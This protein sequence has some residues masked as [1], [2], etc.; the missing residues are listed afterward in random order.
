MQS[1]KPLPL[2]KCNAC[3]FAT[4]TTAD[5]KVHKNDLHELPKQDEKQTTFLHSCITCGYQTNDFNN[6]LEHTETTHKKKSQENLPPT[7]IVDIAE[8]VSVTDEI[9]KNQATESLSDPHLV[10]QL[11]DQ[12]YLSEPDLEW[13][14][15]TEHLDVEC[16]KCLACPITFT[17]Q[18]ILA[19]HTA[20]AHAYQCNK[21]NEVFHQE[22]NLMLHLVN[23]HPDSPQPPVVPVPTNIKCDQCTFIASDVSA[24]VV[25]IRNDH[26]KEQCQY[27]DHE[28]M[29]RDCLKD[30]MYE[31]HAEVV[32]VHTMA[33]QMNQVSENFAAFETFKG[34]L[35]N[36]LN[37]ILNNQTT[38]LDNQNTMKQELFVVRNKQFE[39]DIKASQTKTRH[40]S[41]PKEPEPAMKPSSSSTPSNMSSNTNSVPSP[42]KPAPRVP[43]PRKE[44]KIPNI[45]FI[46]DSISASADVNKLADATQS[47][48]VTAKAYSSSNKTSSNVAKQAPR[49]PASNF[50]DMI[51]KQLSKDDFKYLI[52]QAGSVDISNLNTKDNPLQYMDYF[53]QETIMSADILFSAA[54]NALKN[55][56]GLNKVIIMKQIPRYDPAEVDPLSLKPS[57]SLLF[58]NTMTNNWMESPLKEK[59]YIGNHDIDCNGSIRESRYRHTKSGRYDGVH[60]FGGSGGKFYTLS[61]LNILKNAKIASSQFNFHQSNAQSEHQREQKSNW[62]TVKPQGRRFRPRQKF[63]PHSGPVPTYNR[64]N[65]LNDMDQGNC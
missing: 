19:I 50:T 4:I 30:H 1:A 15:E 52:I 20:Q 56:P 45:L 39:Q 41:S 33:E 11:C 10:C 55:N 31:E 36:V 64:Y 57:L 42:P 7:V 34:E 37:T 49:F 3:S 12:I 8:E 62:Q 17:T 58:N 47:E 28:A 18:A 24:L 23:V 27:C 38:I 63:Q 2:Y 5:L 61:V 44:N 9:Y 16:F 26:T 32:M 54:E 13:H 14:M 60:L 6:L 51:P 35:T 59:I 40:P 43:T 48:V 25:H 46:G 53:R 29:D 21:C 65:G 22:D